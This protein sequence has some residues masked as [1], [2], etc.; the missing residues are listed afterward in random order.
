L[1]NI[2]NERTIVQLQIA[3]IRSDLTNLQTEIHEHRRGEPKY[4]ELMKREYEV[5]QQKNKLEEHYGIL[6]RKER[7]FFSHLQSKIN[8]LHEKS[9]THTRQWGIISTIIGALLG[10]VGTSISAYYRN[11]DIR[12]IQRDIQLQF[13]EQIQQIT[14]DTEQILSG[15]TNLMEFLQ[16]YEMTLKKEERKIVVKPLKSGESWVGYFKRKTVTVWRWCTWQKAS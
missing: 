2:Q 1:H 14:K 5:I 8:M 16:K 9:R 12:R 10:I 13:Q 6:D 4:L 7:E 3:N 11:N 15:Y